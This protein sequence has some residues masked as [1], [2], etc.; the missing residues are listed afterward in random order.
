MF[1]EKTQAKADGDDY[2]TCA[3]CGNTH[4]RSTS[5][6]CPVCGTLMSE[7]YEPL[8][9]IRSSY[10]MQRKALTIEKPAAAASPL[11]LFTVERNAMSD[12]AWACVVYSMGPYLGILFVPLA[13]VIGGIGYVVARQR[14]QL[15]G[16]RIAIVSVGLSFGILVVQ[17]FLW[18][19]LYIIPEIGI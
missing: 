7:D 1:P 5:K 17:I 15:G 19:L 13:F 11:S 9:A 4:S 12:T 16:K 8:D 14:P 6:Y 3:A 18:W 2:R 10:G